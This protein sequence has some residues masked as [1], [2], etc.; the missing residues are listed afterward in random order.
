VKT[1]FNERP[2]TWITAKPWLL[3]LIPVLAISAS[4]RLLTILGS[5]PLIDWD[6]H[7]Y[8]QLAHRIGR[9]DLAG[10]IG[11]RVPLYPSFMLLLRYNLHLVQAAQLMMGLIVTAAIFYTVA[12]LSR[13][14][15]AAGVA[16]ALYGWN[17]AQIRIESTML[18]ETLTTLLVA[19]MG[20][21]MVWLWSDRTHLVTLKLAVL[22]T[23][24]GLLP[25]ARPAYAFVPLVA[26]I[27]AWSWA[28]RSLR[29]LLLVVVVAFV[30]ML[31]WSTFNL[32][33]F[34]SFGL[35]TGLGLNL[36]N[37]TGS[38]VQDAPQKFA[39]FRDLYLRARAE[40]GGNYVNSIWRHYPSMMAVTDKS[41]NQLSASFLRMNEELI[42]THPWQY[43]SNVGAAFIDFFRFW[44]RYPPPLLVLNRLALLVW[45]VESGLNSLV[46]AMFLL[47]VGAW[48]LKAIYR[49]TWRPI[50]PLFWFS[51]I[52]LATDA[53]CA[54]IEWGDSPRFGIPTQPLMFAVVVV[55]GMA[56]FER[57]VAGRRAGQGRHSASTAVTGENRNPASPTGA[58]L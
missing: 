14:P 26:L 8:L 43:A 51:V 56:V 28:P 18:S 6:T 38:Y 3:W 50:T 58:D 21:A 19:L 49:R 46:G 57:F 44:G 11:Q 45:R 22:A 13:R 25:L 9:F 54:V 35:S 37:K 24:A 48:V 10:D 39:V 2:V 20:A 23:C 40:D 55:A 32:V 53:V 17:L 12:T 30:P 36:T 1:S 7:D 16:A 52:V 31:A 4:L 47:F 29:R 42:A 15:V 34:D 27:V 41:F 5:P 33:R